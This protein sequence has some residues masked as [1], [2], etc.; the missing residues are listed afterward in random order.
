MLISR[1]SMLA[2]SLASA[3]LLAASRF[4]PMPALA[5]RRLPDPPRVELGAPLYMDELGRVTVDPV[6]VRIGTLVGMPDESGRATIYISGVPTAS[7]RSLAA[8]FLGH[9]DGLELDR[10]PRA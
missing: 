9:V 4:L 2:R 5:A 1:R 10:P 6:G 8:V 7:R 3:A